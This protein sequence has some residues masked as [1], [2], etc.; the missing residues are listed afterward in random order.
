MKSILLIAATVCFISGSAFAGCGKVVTDKGK[1]KSFDAASKQLVVEAKG[2]EV[3]LTL[4]PG[5]EGADSLADLVGKKVVVESE[6][7][8][9]TSVKAG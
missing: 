4:T 8:K 1:L 7:K 3:T 5:A 9:V 6:H 2:K